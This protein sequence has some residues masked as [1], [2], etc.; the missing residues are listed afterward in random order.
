MI[1]QIGTATDDIILTDR[2]HERLQALVDAPPS[3]GWVRSALLEP[4]REELERRRVVPRSKVSRHV[5]T[6]RSRVEL[7]D[8]DTG[9]RETYTLSYPDEADIDEFKLSVW[10]PLGRAILGQR[11]GR[12]V[13]CETPRG[14]RRLK[15][16]A[17]HYQPEAAGDLDL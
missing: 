15:I 12:E 10:S 11:K 17:I 8:L 13:S 1:G 9:E 14:W 2:D 7:R 4:L 16:E 6:M 3:Y 5:V